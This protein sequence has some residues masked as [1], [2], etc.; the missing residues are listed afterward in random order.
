MTRYAHRR[1]NLVVALTKM[2]KLEAAKHHSAKA[3]KIAPSNSQVRHNYGLVLQKLEEMDE[4]KSQWVQAIELDPTLS[5]SMSSLGHLEGNK[6]NLTGA[7]FWYE[8]ALRIA[9]VRMHKYNPFAIRFADR[10]LIAERKKLVGSVLH[11]VTASHRRDPD[12]IL[13]H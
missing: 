7:K 10:T 8:K 11:K 1:G 3:I 12:D 9:E 13:L 5:N 2:N 4:A 6:G